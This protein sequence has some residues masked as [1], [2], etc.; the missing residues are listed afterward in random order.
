MPRIRTI[1][2]QFWDSPD[3]VGLDPWARLLYIAMWNWA[4]DH[5]RGTADPKALAA[6]AFPK[7][8]FI[9]SAETRRMLGGIRRA[10]GVKFYKVGGRPY[11]YIPSWDR[12][13]KVDKR[14][15][16]RHPGPDQGE[17]YDPEVDELGK[18][19]DSW[20]SAEH[21]AGSPESPPSPRRDPGVGSGKLEVGTGKKFNYSAAPTL[22]IN[23]AV[24]SSEVLAPLAALAPLDAGEGV[25]TMATVDKDLNAGQLTAEWIDYCS[26]NGIAL[27]PTMIKRFAAGIKKALDGRIPGPVIRSALGQMFRDRVLGR[28]ALLD[29]YIM[30]AQQ[31]PELPPERM[32]QLEAQ[33]LRGPTAVDDLIH[34]ILHGES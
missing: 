26:A 15:A 16:V 22:M 10:F 20:D 6:F 25:D 24:S 18:L 17:E 14:S 4:D 2:P 19:P 29:T 11:Y 30:R 3:V 32:S 8:D 28:P 27:A 5:G 34:D 9:D 13:Q 1:K 12:H 7:E 33:L 23:S 31:G 21:S